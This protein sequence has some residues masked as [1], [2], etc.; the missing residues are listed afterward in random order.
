MKGIEPTET[1]KHMAGSVWGHGRTQLMDNN[2]EIKNC[3]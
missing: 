1:E 3:I 2:F